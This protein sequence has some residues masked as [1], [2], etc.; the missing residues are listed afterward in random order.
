VEQVLERGKEFKTV[1]LKSLEV[2]YCREHVEELE[3]LEQ[4]A[5]R[6]ARRV[7]AFAFVASAIACLF[8]LYEPIY[9]WGY[10]A[11]LEF[12]GP[13]GAAANVISTLVFVGI[14]ALFAV[15]LLN[16]AAN[17]LLTWMLRPPVGLKVSSYLGWVKFRFR[18]E[19]IAEE[20]KRLNRDLGA[21]EFSYLSS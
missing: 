9:Q 5:D 3:R 15:A 20:F 7:L 17:Q 8:L 4:K 2:P 14:I 13:V 16:M 19:A 12:L 6:I 10:P 1:K 18:N 21:R 11:M